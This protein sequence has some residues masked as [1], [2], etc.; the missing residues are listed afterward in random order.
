VNAAV[1]FRFAWVRHYLHMLVGTLTG[2]ACLVMLCVAIEA[3]KMV[4][5]RLERS[6]IGELLFTFRGRYIVDI[7]IA[8][9]LC[10]MGFWGVFF[11]G[12]TFLLI[13]G[14]RFLGVKQPDAF[15]EIFRQSDV[16]SQGDSYT[17][18]SEYDAPQVEKR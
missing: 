6:R 15:N 4:T 8:L 9:F 2:I 18:E 13:L 16:E 1:A 17:M 14:I 7:L 5:D 10:A 12:I 3:P 11:A